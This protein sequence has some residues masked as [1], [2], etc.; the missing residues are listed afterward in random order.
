MW[1]IKRGGLYSGHAE[2]QRGCRD[3]IVLMRDFFAFADAVE[4]IL[5]RQFGNRL[6]WVV[7][8]T[9]LFI[10]VYLNEIQRATV[11][12]P[13]EHLLA[14]L[15]FVV[16][17]VLLASFAVALIWEGYTQS[18]HP[19][20][21]AA[22][23]V[24]TKGYAIKF[25]LAIVL[26]LLVVAG[27]HLALLGYF[28]YIHILTVLQRG[29]LIWLT[30]ILAPTAYLLVNPKVRGGFAGLAA[31]FLALLALVVAEWT[32][33]T[34][35]LVSPAWERLGDVYYWNQLF[36][37]V[38]QPRIWLTIY[39]PYLGWYFLGYLGGNLVLYLALVLR[40]LAL[41]RKSA[42]QDGEAK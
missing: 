20:P 2:C 22:C 6:L 12:W 8:G 40:I 39:Q 17:V 19:Q 36:L 16:E 26:L 13:T 1:S 14:L 23:S 18:R 21:D 4:R 24:D 41:E 27:L 37:Q 15:N 32:V 9:G 29:F 38:A 11:R 10:V 35:S 28:Q 5:M 7:V 3:I 25:H 42:K 31:F 34:L 33:V 30:V